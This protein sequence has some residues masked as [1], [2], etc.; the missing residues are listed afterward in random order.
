[1]HLKKHFDILYL[2]HSNN[3]FRNLHGKKIKVNDS[4]EK[5]ICNSY[6]N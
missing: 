1:M 6:S 2:I 4:F 5:D 3:L